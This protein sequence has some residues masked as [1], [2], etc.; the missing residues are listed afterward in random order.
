VAAF[1]LDATPEEI[2]QG[3][4]SVDLASAYALTAYV[5]RHR[6]SVDLY[7]TDRSKAASDVQTEV[8]ARFPPDGP[9]A[10]LLARRA[11]GQ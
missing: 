11:A 5:L 3:Y 2:V 1:D 8:E 7:L 9:R 6:E 10:R 4:P